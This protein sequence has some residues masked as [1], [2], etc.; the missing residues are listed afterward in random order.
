MIERI[1]IYNEKG[2]VIG[3][4]RYSENMDYPNGCYWLHKTN[5]FQEGLMKLYDDRYVLI[6]VFKKPFKRSY[7]K[8]VSAD[9]ALQ[10]I[11]G[12][13]SFELL[14]T[15]KFAELKQL[16]DEILLKETGLKFGDYDDYYSYEDE[17]DDGVIEYRL[18]DEDED[19]WDNCWESDWDIDDEEIQ[20]LS[21]IENG[22][23][24]AVVEYNNNLDF[25]NGVEWSC[26]QSSK[27]K[28]LTRLEDGRYVLIQFSELLDERD[29]AEIVTPERA[30]HEILISDNYNLL[31][32]PTLKDL[33]KLYNKI[34]LQ[35][36]DWD[37]PYKGILV[38]VFDEGTLVGQVWY[39][40][41]LDSQINGRWMYGTWGK[42]RGLTR[43]EDG[44]YVLIYGSSLPKERNYGIVV[45]PEKAA[46]EIIL[47]GHLELFE[48]RFPEL[49]DVAEKIY[50]IPNIKIIN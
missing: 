30:L 16:A 18:E 46:E 29:H 21:V 34:I 47:S 13:H 7:G 4:V 3:R 48:E 36:E 22:R 33:K 24:I 5:G 49:K 1:V 28:G 37:I 42:H 6:Y 35:E 14:E 39:Q 10:E 43:L 19:D 12:S 9:R 2:K 17:D 11:L 20:L 8:V 45:S 44:R 32:Y 27:H 15:K 31:E 25:F 50:E 26:G 40:T 23:I 38:N 41:N